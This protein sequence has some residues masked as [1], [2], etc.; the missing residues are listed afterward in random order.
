[1]KL[2]DFLAWSSELLDF[3]KFEQIDSSKNGLQVGRVEKEVQR[4]SFAVDA[5]LATFEAAAE[6]QSDALFVH[7]GLFWKEPLRVVGSHYHRI[8]FL[9]END[10]ALIAAHLP[11][12]AHPLLGNNATMGA[13]LG[14]MHPQPFGIYRGL[15]IGCYGKL[16]QAAS[17]EEICEKLHFTAE[18]GLHILPFGPPKIETV[19][20]ISGGAAFDVEQAIELGLDA[21]VTGEVNHSVYST[22]KE[23]GI[24]MI[25]GGHYA[26]EVFGVQQIATTCKAKLGLETTFLALPT[27]L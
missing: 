6:W 21:Y 4:I 25:S 23:A 8:K 17:V 1:M 13:L 11:L 14:L 2:K 10:I 16:P 19:G 27:A 18:G 22:C 12:D 5:S 9:L 7:H 24:T 3:A 20:I 26:S 15:P